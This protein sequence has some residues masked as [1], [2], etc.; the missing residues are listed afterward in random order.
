VYGRRNGQVQVE[1]EGWREGSVQH[2]ISGR[3]RPVRFWAPEGG[4]ETITI[5]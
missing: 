3:D 5:F 1:Y 4:F 2:G